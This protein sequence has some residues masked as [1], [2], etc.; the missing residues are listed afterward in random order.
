MAIKFL[1]KEFH[2]ALRLAEFVRSLTHKGKTIPP[3]CRLKFSE[4]IQAPGQPGKTE[5][6]GQSDHKNSVTEK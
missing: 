1:S 3:P 5:G 2:Q 6:R 4:L